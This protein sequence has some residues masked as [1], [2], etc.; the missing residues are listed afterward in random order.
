MGILNLVEIQCTVLEKFA[1][2]WRQVQSKI[3]V[4]EFIDGAI[5]Y[6]EEEFVKGKESNAKKL[7]MNCA[8]LAANK[9]N[10]H[11]MGAGFAKDPFYVKETRDVYRTM[12][13]DP[14]D[15]MTYM[16][17]YFYLPLFV[18]FAG[19]AVRLL[20]VWLE[21]P[22]VW[23]VA[24]YMADLERQLSDSIAD[25]EQRKKEETA[26]KAQE[27]KDKK[28]TQQAKDEAKTEAEAATFS[29][30]GDALSKSKT[31]KKKKKQKQTSEAAA[32]S[33][34]DGYDD[35]TKKENEE[36]TE[37]VT[38]ERQTSVNTETNKQV[39]L[40]SVQ[41]EDD[42]LE[43][44]MPPLVEDEDEC[45][46]P[47][48]QLFKDW[49]PPSPEPIA[50]TDDHDCWPM[51]DELG[52]PQF[53]FLGFHCNPDELD[54]KSTDASFPLESTD[55]RTDLPADVS[56]ADFSKTLESEGDMPEPIG[57]RVTQ[58]EEPESEGIVEQ[59]DMWVGHKRMI[60][61]DARFD[62]KIEET[63]ENKQSVGESV[64][65]S[66]QGDTHK[67]NL[68][69]Q[70]GVTQNADV[71]QS[72]DVMRHE[73]STVSCPPAS[74]DISTAT[75][76]TD[77]PVDTNDSNHESGLVCKT[78]TEVSDLK[79]D[80]HLEVPP[81]PGGS[82][83]TTDADKS[84]N[85]VNTCTDDAEDDDRDNDDVNKHETNKKDFQTSREHG[86]TPESRK[87]GSNDVEY[88]ASFVTPNEGRMQSCRQAVGY[89]GKNT[90]DV[91]KPP[92]KFDKDE[93]VKDDDSQDSADESIVDGIS[94]AELKLLTTE[95]MKLEHFDIQDD[96]LQLDDSQCP[97]LHTKLLTLDRFGLRPLQIVNRT[98]D[99]G[100]VAMDGDNKGKAIKEATKETSCNYDSQLITKASDGGTG[101]TTA[102]VLTTDS[103]SVSDSVPADSSERIG[104]TYNFKAEDIAAA[105]RKVDIFARDQDIKPSRQQG[106]NQS[107]THSQTPAV[108]D[109]FAG[110]ARW[111]DAL[112]NGEP[113]STYDGHFRQSVFTTTYKPSITYS[114]PGP[115]AGPLK[116]VPGC[117]KKHSIIKRNT[118][119]VHPESQKMTADGK[120][121]FPALTESSMSDSNMQELMT[122]VTG[123]IFFVTR[124]GTYSLLK[125]PHWASFYA[126]YICSH[127]CHMD[128]ESW[129]QH[130]QIWKTADKRV[131]ASREPIEK[132]TTGYY[133]S[134]FTTY[135]GVNIPLLYCYLDWSM[136]ALSNFQFPDDADK[137]CALRIVFVSPKGNEHVLDFLTKFLEVS[138]PKTIEMYVFPTFEMAQKRNG[139]IKR[140]PVDLVER[141]AVVSAFAVVEHKGDINFLKTLQERIVGMSV[142]RRGLVD[143]MDLA[144]FTTQKDSLPKGMA[145]AMKSTEGKQIVSGF[146]RASMNKQKSDLALL[147]GI[148]RINI[149]PSSRHRELLPIQQSKAASAIAT[150]PVTK[151]SAKRKRKEKRRQ[152]KVDPAEVLRTC[153]NCG[154]GE[155]TPKS[156]KKCKLCLDRPD[157]RYYC[158]RECQ[159]QDWKTKHRLDHNSKK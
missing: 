25:N 75:V 126:A 67:E 64:R 130:P 151:S 149:N 121:E 69:S 71:N 139:V 70:N 106:T 77:L 118:P 141:P 39:V 122:K 4:K 74:E 156:F 15:G 112:C 24:T 63:T 97:M 45:I 42:E 73:S 157:A 144:Y 16:R 40:P 18:K 108:P 48:A 158:S 89:P 50:Y 124:L 29:T 22:E 59:M 61:A 33:T 137:I 111:I 133:S 8:F 125:N 10:I 105:N 38:D 83:S 135:D 109:E 104:G 34:V 119:Y 51:K 132:F 96:V 3:N 41:L 98:G 138:E 95:L 128:R 116:K 14:N 21:A 110:G 146:F 78:D 136:E 87:G 99:T 76:E 44:D 11:R 79:F 66:H 30:D 147:G 117:R 115:D 53:P 12:F 72:S 47:T 127:S 143:E 49:R 2:K 32:A 68:C 92:S 56:S 145:E 9:G 159:A 93:T 134:V 88:H 57:Q 65:E 114:G 90:R 19:A 131:S 27:R 20:Q 52:Q 154:K 55:E 100:K 6:L 85:K 152:E 46:A 82:H 103:V 26:R 23:D 129:R 5:N 123:G 94:N 101:M 58:E 13:G 17:G 81:P 107:I 142:S 155:T 148:N 37:N 31:K 35:D 140:V 54:E 1:H 84:E 150:K 28:Q 113:V 91:F 153:S 86:F 120:H 60:H 43:L 7:I 62:T 36:S 80:L 102:D